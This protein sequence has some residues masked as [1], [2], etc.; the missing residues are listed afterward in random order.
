MLLYYSLRQLHKGYMNVMSP[1]NC[2]ITQPICKCSYQTLIQ[3]SGRVDGGKSCLELGLKVQVVPAQ[4]RPRPRRAAPV[5][6][7]GHQRHVRPARVPL[8]VRGQLLSRI[9]HEAAAALVLRSSINVIVIHLHQLM[10]EN[11]SSSNTPFIAT[12]RDA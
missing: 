1:Q 4:V 3:L 6:R 2:T 7:R 12:Q 10:K 11:I 8:P 5:P 9:E